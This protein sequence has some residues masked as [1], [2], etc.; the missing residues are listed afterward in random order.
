M[1]RRFIY[2]RATDSMVEVGP[3]YVPETGRTSYQVMPDIQPYKS[4]IDGRVITSRSHHRE[5]L[6]SHGCV[7]VGNDSSLTRQPQPL[8]SPPGLKQALIDAA[9]QCLRSK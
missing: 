4:M 7:E 6:R 5:H 2:D 3:E 1:R 9:N 8:K